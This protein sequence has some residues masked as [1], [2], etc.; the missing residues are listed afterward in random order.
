MTE[1][2]VITS[3]FHGARV[4]KVFRA[5]FDDC[6]HFIVLLF[7]NAPATLTEAQ[8]AREARAES[9]ML[10]KFDA[11]LLRHQA[12]TWWW[13]WW[14][15]LRWKFVE[16]KANGSALTLCIPLLPCILTYTCLWPCVYYVI[17]NS[18]NPWPQVFLFGPLFKIFPVARWSK[19]KV[20][21]VCVSVRSK[22][23][24]NWSDFFLH[25]APRTGK[26]TAP[27]GKMKVELLKE[28]RFWR[29]AGNQSEGNG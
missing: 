12:M 26:K 15:S 2:V 1:V 29:E 20:W 21:C 18:V 5:V 3:D 6:K 7:A 24:E 9:Q 23:E 16:I 14:S 8:K 22:R 10:A 27:C 19:K 13:W 28:V 11:D 17:Q 4:E 25:F